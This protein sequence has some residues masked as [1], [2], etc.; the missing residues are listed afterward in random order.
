VVADDA[1]FTARRVEIAELAIKN[2]LPNVS[3]LRELAEAG[4][5]MAYGASFGDLYKRAASHVSKILRGAKASDLPIEQPV[6]FEFVLNMRTAK[7][8]GLSFRHH[9]CPS[10]TRSSSKGRYFRV[11]VLRRR[12]KGAGLSAPPLKLRLQLVPLLQWHRRPQY[13]GIGRCSRSSY[14]PTGVGPLAGCLCADR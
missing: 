12:K 5:L 3:G 14:A 10:P 13:R 8:L 11:L 4:G 9:W 7:L 6:K 2:R 1:E